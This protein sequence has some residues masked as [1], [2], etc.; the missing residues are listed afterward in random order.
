MKEG[1]FSS[2]IRLLEDAL[3]VVKSADAVAWV[4]YLAGV[5]P[6]FGALLFDLTDLM[7]NPFA[8]ERL[9][10]MTLVLAVFYMW[11][12]ICQSVFCGRLYATVTEQP[13]VLKAQ[14]TAAARTQTILAGSKLL[15]W[16]LAVGLIV[17]YPAVT[18]F[19]QHSLLPEGFVAEAKR[20]ATYRQAQAASML[21]SVLLFRALLWINLLSLLFMAPQLWKTFTGLESKVTRAPQILFNP[22]SIAALCVL[23]YLGLDPIVK[24][25]CVLRRFARQSERSGQDLSLKLRAIQKGLVASLVIGLFL[26]P[27]RL[28]AVQPNEVSAGQMKRAMEQ[29][30]HDPANRWDLPVVQPRK[31]ASGP[32][33]TFVDSIADH[34]NHLW[35]DLNMAIQRFE[36]WLR[37]VMPQADRMGGHEQRAA[38]KTDVSIVVAIF[39]ALLAIAVVV[40][41][42]NRRKHSGPQQAAA[43]AVAAPKIDALEQ[44]VHA[45]DQ[46]PGDWLQLAERYR[47]GGDFRLALRAL[48]LSILATLG[49]NGLI[50][51]ARGKSNLD[52]VRELQRRAKRRGPEFTD[53]FRANVRMF[54]ET[55]YGEHPATEKTLENFLK[56]AGQLQN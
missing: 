2:A 39:S 1:A 31:H 53:L 44:E 20:D 17:T 41:M 25:A 14:F 29:V 27:L 8:A 18:M 54:E 3:S 13:S 36:E 47:M 28:Y 12:H 50:S 52:Y 9:A 30:F 55:W 51:L 6:F 37:R 49:E 43:M 5:V 4:V 35:D 23:A 56:N 10:W 19:Y 21:A 24:A 34:V 15:V 45:A 33:E 38:S 42:W 46:A 7:Q 48:Y 22:T 16:P 26:I 32:F 40:A 11:M